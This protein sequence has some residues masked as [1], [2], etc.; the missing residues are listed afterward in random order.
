[1]TWSNARGG[2]RRVAFPEQYGEFSLDT[3]VLFGEQEIH[4]LLLLIIVH[5][6]GLPDEAVVGTLAFGPDGTIGRMQYR[7]IPLDE[8]KPFDH[9]GCRVRAS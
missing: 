5:K 8:L 3:D 4:G 6:D 7:C 9:G 1:M 2:N